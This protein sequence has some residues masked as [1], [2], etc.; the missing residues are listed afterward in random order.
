MP[1][2]DA[3]VRRGPERAR[4]IRK[5]H[6]IGIFDQVDVVAIEQNESHFLKEVNFQILMID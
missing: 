4:Y 6:H 5:P 2:L 3:S 1:V